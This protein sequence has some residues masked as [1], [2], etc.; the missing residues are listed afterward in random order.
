MHS[1]APVRSYAE[2]GNTYA[3]GSGA[4]IEEAAS[5]LLEDHLKVLG[6]HHAAL[7][8]AINRVRKIADRLLGSE[9]AA[10]TGGGEA[11]PS[12]QPPL[13]I[14]VEHAARDMTPT[15]EGLHAQIQRLERI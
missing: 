2:V 7:W 6:Q 9:P 13:V 15:L 1:N 10:L 4:A 12:A 14:R 5:T 8:E 3:A 11:K